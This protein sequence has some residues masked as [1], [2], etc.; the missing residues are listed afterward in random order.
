MSS[1]T[2]ENKYSITDSGWVM[3][4]TFCKILSTL[5][6]NLPSSLFDKCWPIL[7]DKLSTVSKLLCT[8]FKIN[9]CII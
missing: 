6:K 1:I 2:D 8:I 3:Y 9:F 7:A 4:E 5:N